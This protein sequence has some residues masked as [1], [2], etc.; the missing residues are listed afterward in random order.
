MSVAT[1]DLEEE[2]ETRTRRQPPYAVILHNDDDNG[3]DWVVKVLQKVF[4]YPVEKCFQHMMEA[5]EKGKSAVWVG[6]LEVAEL[7]ADQIHSCGGDPQ[8]KKKAE[9]LR[10]TVEPTE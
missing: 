4:T 2:T 1:P 8:A 5:H 6:M 10:V 3:M 9:P 7:K